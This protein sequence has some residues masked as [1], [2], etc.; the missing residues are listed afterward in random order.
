MILNTFWQRVKSEK[1]IKIEMCKYIF[2]YKSMLIFNEI[3][4]IMK[5]TK[6][7]WCFPKK[8]SNLLLHLR[9]NKH[10]VWFWAISGVDW[11]MR[12]LMKIKKCK[13]MPSYK[14]M[15]YGNARIF[16]YSFD[17]N[18]QMLRSLLYFYCLNSQMLRC[19]RY[20]DIQRR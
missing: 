14:S 10:I 16:A 2:S 15:R 1:L 5:C 4:H 8:V 3:F 20:G 7:L 17:L 12:N 19:V 6:N 11:S 18:S 13:F 9:C